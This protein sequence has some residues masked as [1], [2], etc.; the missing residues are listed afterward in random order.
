MG[1]ICFSKDD[2]LVG[3]IIELYGIDNVISLPDI[4]LLKEKDLHVSEIIIVDLKYSEMPKSGKLPLPA[5][6]LTVVPTFPEALL[7]LQRGV[8]GYGNRQMRKDN[9]EQT[10]K[11]VKAG[12]IWLPPSI[13]TQLVDTVGPVNSVSLNDSLLSTLSKREQ[14]VAHCVA[15]G[16][17]N[18]EI[19]DKMFV[20]LRTIKAHLTSIYEKTG[21]RNRLEL[22]LSMKTPKSTATC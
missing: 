3:K 13:I 5:I 2:T 8:R 4:Q 18:K 11:S 19:A 15:E 17:S 1:I 6:V 16:M 20:S 22:G 7:L 14:E 21:L 10:I 12:Q 9:L